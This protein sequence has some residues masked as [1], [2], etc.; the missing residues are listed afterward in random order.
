[1]TVSPRDPNASATELMDY[2]SLDESLVDIALTPSSDPPTTGDNPLTRSSNALRNS[3]DIGSSLNE[4][5]V[6]R[7]L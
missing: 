2:P 7:G 4:V 3:K 6:P 5:E 1:M